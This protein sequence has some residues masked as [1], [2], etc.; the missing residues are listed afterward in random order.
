MSVFQEVSAFRTLVDAGNSTVDVAARFGI[1]ENLVNCRLA[2][3]RLSPVLWKLYEEEEVTLGVLQ[4]FTLIDD[5]NTQERIWNELPT[6]DRDKPNVI[7]ASC[8]RRKSPPL[9]NVFASSALTPMKLLAALSTATCFPK[10]KT[11]L[12]SQIQDYS[13]G[14]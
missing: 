6:W 3:A 10:A 5:H 12:P 9:T 2:L 8:L 7:R 14:W 1:S 11:A 4:A 13:H